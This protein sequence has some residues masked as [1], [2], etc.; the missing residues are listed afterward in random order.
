[1][2][3]AARCQT[4]EIDPKFCTSNKKKISPIIIANLHLPSKKGNYQENTISYS[5]ASS[6]KK[7]IS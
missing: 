1:M 2:T 6:N 4:L 7:L 3:E 5:S